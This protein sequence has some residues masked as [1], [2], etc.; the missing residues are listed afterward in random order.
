MAG[1]ASG[2]LGT[3]AGE[4][5][6]DF[7]M[8]AREAMGTLGTGAGEDVG[9]LGTEAEEASGTLGTGVGLV[10]AGSV[11]VW[12][13]AKPGGTAGVGSKSFPKRVAIRRSSGL[14]V[15]TGWVAVL[16]IVKVDPGARACLWQRSGVHGAEWC[17]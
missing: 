3:G 2:T 17:H 13:G 11:G 9:T 4:D 1:E 15:A 14:V 7:G 16:E 6:G 5:A 10:G 12:R 8:E